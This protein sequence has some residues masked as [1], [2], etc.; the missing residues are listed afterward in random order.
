MSALEL[1]EKALLLL[2]FAVGRHPWND[3]NQ[4][5][6]IACDARLCGTGKVAAMAIT[7]AKETAS[8][9]LLSAMLRVIEQC[10]HVTKENA[11][12]N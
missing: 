6:L 5:M 7:D 9:A 1:N 12:W 4:A 2:G 8:I 3:S 10:A 11:E